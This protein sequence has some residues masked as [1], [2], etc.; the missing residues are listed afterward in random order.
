MSYRIARGFLVIDNKSPDGDTIAFAMDEEHRGEW[1]WPYEETGRF[2]K[3]NRQFQANIRFEAIDA[4][5]LHYEIPDVYP[6]VKTHQPLDLAREARD[7]MLRICGFDL[8]R[9]TENADLTLNDPDKQKKPA[10]IAYREIDPYGRLVAFVFVED[11]GFKVDGSHPTVFLEPEQMERS[12]NVQLLREGLA[13]P[14]FYGSLYPELR[15]PL[16][17]IVRQA[18]ENRL[19]LWKRDIMEFTSSRKP[20]LP[21]VEDIVIM[22]KIFRRLSMHIACNGALSNFKEYLGEVNDLTVD[23]RQVRLTGFESFIAVDSDGPGQYTMKLLR[24]PE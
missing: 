22:P 14:T 20:G 13:Y 15:G 23:T 1:V 24:Y 10:T 19:G 11:M 4:L 18:R 16:V 5:E 8:T 3:F 2:P 17:E 9:V 12:V 7:R 21:E 6:V